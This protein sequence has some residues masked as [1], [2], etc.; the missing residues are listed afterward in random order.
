MNVHE[1]P[2]GEYY[3]TLSLVVK[4]NIPRTV[5][6]NQKIVNNVGTEFTDLA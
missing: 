2:D 4:S 5:I 6:L 3:Y 1:Y